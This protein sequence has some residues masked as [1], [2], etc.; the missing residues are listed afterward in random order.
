MAQ[1]KRYTGHSIAYRKYLQSSEWRRFRVQMI[2]LRNYRCEHCGRKP[3]VLE[4]HHKHYRNLTR[5]TANDVEVLCQQCHRRAD[6]IRAK[7]NRHKPNPNHEPPQRI[8]RKAAKT[9][10]ARIIGQLDKDMKS[11]L[12]NNL[13]EI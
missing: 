9:R 13:K 11:W 3:R 12:K 4:V 6:W 5:E 7:N 8:V 2:K 1:R 10:A